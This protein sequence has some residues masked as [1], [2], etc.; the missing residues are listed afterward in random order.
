MEDLAVG[1]L[2]EHF[3]KQVHQLADS[4]KDRA[5]FNSQ[6]CREYNKRGAAR[7]EL[8]LKGSRY[9]IADGTETRLTA[10][11]LIALA[12]DAAFHGKFHPPPGAHD[13]KLWNGDSKNGEKYCVLYVEVEHKWNDFRETIG[14]LFHS[15]Q[16]QKM[17]HILPPRS[18][19]DEFGARVE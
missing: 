19:C 18:A 7:T 11:G 8:M 16:A 2:A 14:D 5:R 1:L 3:Q 10:R 15:Q 17:G 13:Y 9:I 12:A 4:A 6:L